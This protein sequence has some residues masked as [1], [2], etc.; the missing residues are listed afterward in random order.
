M[1]AMILAAGRGVRMQSL[2][3]NTPKPLLKVKNTT[4][5]EHNLLQLK[6]AGITEV[7]INVCY[8]A[9]QII[10]KLGDG[11]QYGLEIHYSVEDALLDTGGGIKKALPLLGD[12]AFLV[13]SSDIWTDYPFENLVN[14]TVNGAH[15][16]LVD[17]PSYHASGDF[18][19]QDNI[20]VEKADDKLTY[21][22]IAVM[23]PQLFD[24]YEESV[25]PLSTVFRDAMSKGVVTGEHYDGVWFNVGT[26]EELRAVEMVF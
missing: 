6:Q 9:D 12:A 16:V 26:P 13:L 5:I 10:E 18:G 8:L 23:H 3:D 22:S 19:L 15:L 14:K 1:K 24:G 7:V 4:L 11:S 25:F 17:N 20:V 21:S 2:T